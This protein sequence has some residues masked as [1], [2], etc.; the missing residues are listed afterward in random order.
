VIHDPYQLIHERRERYLLKRGEDTRLELLR[1][2]LYFKIEVKLSLLPEA[3]N[4]REQTLRNM[5]E[6]WGWTHDHLRNLNMRNLWK[7]QR[8][9]EEH[10]SLVR[11][12]TGSY[13]FLQEFARDNKA[14]QLISSHE[15][16]VLGRKLFSYFERQP[17]KIE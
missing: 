4:W 16:T 11:E 10:H 2:P 15:M 7:V 8:A 1:K 9:R 13:R 5:T 6:T 3:A 17:D 14:E 12:L